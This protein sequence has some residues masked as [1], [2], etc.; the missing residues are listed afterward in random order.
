MSR[1]LDSAPTGNTCFV[2]TEI[3]ESK[4]GVLDHIKQANENW[5]DQSANLIS[6]SLLM[7]AD[8]FRVHYSNHGSGGDNTIQ[9]ESPP[10]ARR[11]VM[12]M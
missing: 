12:G 7:A 10:A 3:Y 1:D 8:S 2:L 5:A 11:T 6:S 9:A 4:A